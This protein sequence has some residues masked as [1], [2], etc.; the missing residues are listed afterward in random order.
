MFAIQA[1]HTE[2]A[3]KHAWIVRRMRAAHLVIVSNGAFILDFCRGME[4]H[5]SS[6]FLLYATL[7]TTYCANL[8]HE[9]MDCVVKTHLNAVSH[10]WDVGTKREKEIRST[11]VLANF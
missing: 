10:F 5:T 9:H 3:F 11:F 7:Q 8:L 6:R 4:L 1:V 2:D